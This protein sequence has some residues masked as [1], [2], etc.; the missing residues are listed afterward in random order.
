MTMMAYQTCPCGLEVELHRGRHQADPYWDV[1]DPEDMP[2]KLP[3]GE[4]VVDEVLRER[5]AADRYEPVIVCRCGRR[6]EAWFDPPAVTGVG[7][8]GWLA[9]RLRT[10]VRDRVDRARNRTSQRW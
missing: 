1:W 9:R 5:A 8:P 2:P 7:R 4:V 6:Y 3:P 10:N